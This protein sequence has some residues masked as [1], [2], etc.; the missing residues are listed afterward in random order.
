MDEADRIKSD[1]TFV[2]DISTGSTGA[3]TLR[4]QRLDGTAVAATMLPAGTDRALR[5]SLLL[6]LRLS[7]KF[8]PVFGQRRLTSMLPL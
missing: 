1:G 5:P 4:R 2:F 3:G 7:C 8:V 6:T